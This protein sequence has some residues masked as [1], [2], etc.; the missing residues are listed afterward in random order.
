MQLENKVLEPLK[1]YLQHVVLHSVVP[2]SFISKP[3]NKTI[4]ETETVAFVCNVSGNPT[5]AITWF[6]GGQT[7]G[8]GK[9]L[10]F[11]VFRNQSGY[12]LCLTDN[13]LN[14][15]LNASAYLDVHC[16]FKSVCEYLSS[17]TRL[18]S[19]HFIIYLLYISLKSIAI[20]VD[21]KFHCVPRLM[22]SNN[23]KMGNT[24]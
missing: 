1:L 9:T 11:P 7:V 13:D 2:V 6:R 15:T 14:V 8:T 16:K 20:L 4:N 21:E 3:T 19:Y 23:N 10:S 17:C 24:P 12:Y 22:D 5:P 18:C